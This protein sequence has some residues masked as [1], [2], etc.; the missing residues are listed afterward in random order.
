MVGLRV[1]R[2]LASGREPTVGANAV[3]EHGNAD[4]PA[5]TDEHP[6]TIVDGA[7]RAGE[8]CRGAADPERNRT[9]HRVPS[10]RQRAIVGDIDRPR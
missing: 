8:R 5:W 4:A 7:A 6:G 3:C 2:D 10:T 9:T 1:E